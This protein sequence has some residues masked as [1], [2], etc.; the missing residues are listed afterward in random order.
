MCG[1]V[2]LAGVEDAALVRCMAEAVAHRGPDGEGFFVGD[3]VSLG[4]RRLS[5]IDPAG[6][7]QPLWS[8]D[9]Q[10][11]T[12]CN[13][14][15][16][17][18]RRLRTQ[19][20]KRGHSFRTA[21]DAETIVHAHEEY[22]DAGVHLLRGMFA[23]AVWD[24]RQRRLLLVRDRLGIKPLYY[25]QAGAT[26][27]FAS[28]VKALL[29][30]PG[31]SR[32][33]DVEALQRY[34]TLGYVPGPATILT[35]VRKLPPGHRLAWQAGRVEVRQYWDL[36]LDEGARR[37]PAR[38]AAEAFREQ[39]EDSVAHHQISDVPLGVLLSGGIDSA[40]V[41][42]LLAGGGRRVKTFTVGFEAG[43]GDEGELVAA[44][45][46][47]RHFDTEHHEIVLGSGLAD[48]LPEIVR[49]QDEPLADPATVATF[50]VCRL[51]A[52][53]VKVVLTGEGGDELLGG[54]PRYG[55]LRLGERLRRR[56]GLRAAARALLASL[57]H[58][59]AGGRISQRLAT[60]VGPAALEDRHL[61]WVATL[62]GDV[63]HALTGDG[64]RTAAG[65]LVRELVGR[66]GTGDPVHDLMYADVKTWLPDDVLVK[67]DRMSMAASIE[68]RVPLLDHRLMEF[69]ASLPASM[70]AGT[71]ATKALL[72]QA[73]G[74][75]LPAAT[76]RRRKRAF[77]VPLRRWLGGELRELLHDSLTSASARSRGLVRPEA[78]ARLLHEQRS[79]R[80]DHG[81][82]LWT[83]LCLE[84]WLTTVGDA[85][86]AAHD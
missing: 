43:D 24:R 27:A 14:E 46:V 1:I 21:G 36:V 22:G 67:T 70:K 85:A 54:Y 34:L 58:G 77:L 16:Y 10:V 72:R 57:P 61:D 23:Y 45:T 82:A 29:A 4:M 26:L 31:V 48:I 3:G 32:A 68:A 38:A 13:G 30:V 20:E 44:R 63:Q 62:S 60:L 33:L 19:L 79:G 71:L 11:L 41:T 17:N 28:E 55:W 15:I 53:S 81:R 66:S 59:V 8:E 65:A 5:I 12:I 9:R 40:A 47:A 78:V 18:Y 52:G 75:D 42:A 25:A 2:G 74:R 39:L 83:L 6:S 56:P 7:D 35:A 69:T 84:L 86:A 80:H 64:G 37:L 76:R 49:M 51:A 50:F 73:L